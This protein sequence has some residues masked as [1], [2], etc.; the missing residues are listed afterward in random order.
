MVTDQSARLQDDVDNLRRAHNVLADAKPGSDEYKAALEA[1]KLLSN[2]IREEEKAIKEEELFYRK[3]VEDYENRKW[4]KIEIAKDTVLGIGGI[5]V[6]V[7]AYDKFS[8]RQLLFE[9]E[10][11]VSTNTGRNL[12]NKIPNP[13]KH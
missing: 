5:I 10:G 4:K 9:K 6:P 8:K 11:I 7:W 13:F 12:L 1:I 2:E 3:H